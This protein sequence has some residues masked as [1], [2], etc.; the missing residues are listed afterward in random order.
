MATFRKL[1][2][3][4][5][6]HKRR[7]AG[8]LAFAGLAVAVFVAGAWAGSSGALTLGTTPAVASHAMHSPAPHGHD[9]DDSPMPAREMGP[10]MKKHGEMPPGEMGPDK[11]PMKPGMPMH[12]SDKK[13]C[14][15]A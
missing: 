9:S 15:K 5:G 14:D 12:K 2:T 11:K 10:N 1:R 7:V 4:F 8:T 13:C 6:E 3:K